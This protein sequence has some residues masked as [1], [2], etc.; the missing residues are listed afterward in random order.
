MESFK[1]ILSAKLHGIRVTDANL[2]YHGSITL[3]P[4]YCEKLGICPLEFVEIWNKNNGQRI[5]TYVI[6]GEKGSHCCVLNGSAARTCEIGDELIIASY[7]FKSVKNLEKHRPKV[8][9]FNADNSIKET[10][11]YVISKDNK[12]KYLFNIVHCN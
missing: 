6:F 1:K 11:E 2:N 12:D 8:F 9:I 7:D 10:L 3:D 5:S 4:E